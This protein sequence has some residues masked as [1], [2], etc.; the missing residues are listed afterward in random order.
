MASFAYQARDNAGAEHAGF[1]DAAT[2]QEA[3]KMLRDQGRFIIKL[4]PAKAVAVS[5]KVKRS[6]KKIK[7]R[8]VIVFCQQLAVMIETGVPIGEALECLT[9]QCPEESFREVLSI[10]QVKVNAGSGLSEALADFPSIFPTI[11]IS[12]VRAAEASGTLGPMLSTISQYMTKEQKTARKIKGALTYPAVM[13]ALVFVVTSFLVMF[14]LPSFAGIYAD[15]G[16]ALPGPTRFLMGVSGFAQN[17]WH[18]TIGSLVGLTV[19]GAFFFRTPSGQV[20]LDTIKLKTPLIGGLFSKLYLTRSFR[21]MGTM[22]S[23]GVP[24]LD[25]VQIV[26]HVTP[27]SYYE[28]LWDEV[29]DSLRKGGQLSDTF[30]TSPLVPKSVSQM[31]NSGER[32]GRLPEVMSR[33]AEFTEEEF[34]EQVAATTQYLE[35]A[36]TVIMGCVIGFVAIALLLPIFSV[37]SMMSG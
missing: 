8:Q 7:P 17:W 14:V 20:T 26:R 25:M 6:G 24:I 3:S 13:L 27:N 18:V 10:V 9:E 37:G 35:P 29:D 36:I 33:V 4:E 31:V 28:A 34:D 32:A 5:A 21:T 30:G 11:M 12:L 22:I 2:L 15:R 23:A 16:A 1:L 19:G